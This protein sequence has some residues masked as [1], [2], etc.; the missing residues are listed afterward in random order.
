MD[1]SL[2]AAYVKDSLVFVS[3]HNTVQPWVVL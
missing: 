2:Q 3:Q 1:I